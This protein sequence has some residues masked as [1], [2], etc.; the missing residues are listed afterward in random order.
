MIVGPNSS[1][2]S[3]LL[4]DINL[5]VSGEVR[6]LVVA[7]KVDLRKPEYEPFLKTLEREGYLSTFYDDAGALTIR[8]KTAFLGTGSGG[9]QIA[10]NQ[11]QSWHSAFTPADERRRKIEFLNY[12]GRMIV[13][14]LFL[15]RRLTLVNQVGGFDYE[16]QPPQ[17]D[18]QALY[19]NSTAKRELAA[20]VIRSFGRAVW[21][22]ASRGPV[23]CL[24]V[25]DSPTVPDA[26]ERHEPGAMTRYRT[27]ETEGDGLKSYVATCIALLLGQ[28]PVCVIDEPE[29]CL[30]PPQ[31]Y[32]LGRFIGRFG[33]STENVTFVATHSSHILRGI[34]QTAAS[35]QIVR[36][37][38][39]ASGF[40]AYL[41]PREALAES[42]RRPN[43]RAEA[44]LDGIFAQAV[45]V[46]EA[47]GDRLVYQAVFETVA[48]QYQLDVHFAAV[49]GT[50]GLANTCTLYRTLRIPVVVI[51]D[52]DIVTDPDNKLGRVL[53]ALEAEQT[54]ELVRR[55]GEI[56]T[57]LKSLPP[58]L[59][60]SDAKHQVQLT[61]ERELDWAKGSDVELQKALQSIANRLDR[62]RRLKKGG[63]N[64]LPTEIAEPLKALVGD[65]REAG[66]FLVPVGELEE[67][68]AGRGVAPSKQE[69]WA[70]AN[71]A[72]SRVKELGAQ[73]GDVWDFVRNVGQY[74]RME[75]DK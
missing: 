24:R 8:P 45:V 48:D 58:V 75:F 63:V 72:A 64:N 12:F 32:N 38:R 68:L 6:K 1:G 23:L 25:S 73:S 4:Q 14:A 36:L 44:V 21:L 28:R 11:A 49:G 16:S 43:L 51:A 2:K 35:L 54:E 9:A 3:Q 15:D 20:E 29:M 7:E 71:E 62:M 66:L 61:I 55:A 27:I 47:D 65:L 39:S 74:L 40:H 26:E 18:L 67:W 37:T 57:A 33:T 22:D 41:V 19:L 13:T 34:V 56:A 50:G 52:L 46:V 59:S 5:R 60:E 69:K 53:S 30:H 70:W 10:G 42:L 17:N 31:A